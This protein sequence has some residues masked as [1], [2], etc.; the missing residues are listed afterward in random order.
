LIEAALVGQTL[1]P[2]IR[3]IVA[4][5]VFGPRREIGGVVE[6]WA[7]LT[8]GSERG[9]MKLA[10]RLSAAAARQQPEELFFVVFAG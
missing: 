1:G 2:N 3:S 9:I 5:R 10:A 6:L 7:C 8:A 4:S